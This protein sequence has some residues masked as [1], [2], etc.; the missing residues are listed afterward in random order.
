M[1][2]PYARMAFSEFEFGIVH[3]AVVAA[4]AEAFAKWRV[5]EGEEH[6]FY[7]VALARFDALLAKFDAVR[8]ADTSQDPEPELLA[9]DSDG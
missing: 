4:R 3:G 2:S 9:D 1:A 7:A 5:T 8:I 6:V